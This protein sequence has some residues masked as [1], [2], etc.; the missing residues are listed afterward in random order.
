MT[1][2]DQCAAANRHSGSQSDGSDNLS[3]TFAADQVFPEAIAELG[4]CRKMKR[5][6]VITRRIERPLRFVAPFTDGD[7]ALLF[8]NLCPDVQSEEQNIISDEIIKS[9]ARYVACWG[10]QC[11][12]WDT[13][14]DISFIGTDPDF[15]PP[16]DRF[17]MTTWHEKEP[18]EDTFEF[19]WIN[20]YIDGHL[21]SK[22]G[23]FILGAMRKLKPNCRN[24][25]SHSQI[26]GIKI[27]KKPDKAMQ[28][29]PVNVAVCAYARPALFTSAPD[30]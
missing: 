13:S 29:T 17:V 27:M 15:N 3:A 5:E 10:H 18:I 14:M 30:L 23:V 21:P 8:V 16:D 20:G 19:L 9:R 28:T 12:A 11:S 22:I 25:Q 7:Y 4:H 26:N 6:I 24:W 2:P 1:W